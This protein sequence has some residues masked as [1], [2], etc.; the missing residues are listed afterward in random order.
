M[1][2]PLGPVKRTGYGLAAGL[3]PEVSRRATAIT[4]SIPAASATRPQPDKLGAA[5][6]LVSFVLTEGDGSELALVPAA[7]VAVTVNV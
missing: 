7:L 4:A 2:L 6:G 5:E 1:S 3:L